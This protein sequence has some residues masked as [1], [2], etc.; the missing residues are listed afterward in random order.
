MCDYTATAARL[1]VGSPVI[2]AGEPC[3]AALDHQQGS[4]SRCLTFNE[5]IQ[6]STHM[7]A[8]IQDARVSYHPR[9]RRVLQWQNHNGTV[10]QG[11]WQQQ[12]QQQH[13]F[14]NSSI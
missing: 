10:A 14:A 1:V 13:K 5:A 2:P 7:Y 6:W 8:R 12:Q 3:Q 4:S 9:E 11:Q